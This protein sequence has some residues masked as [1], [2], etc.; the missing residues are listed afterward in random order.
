MLF[1]MDEQLSKNK[2]EGAYTNMMY[3]TYPGDYNAVQDNYGID[4]NQIKACENQGNIAHMY[5]D[6]AVRGLVDIN[7]YGV[8]PMGGMV[9]ARPEGALKVSPISANEVPKLGYAL[10]DGIYYPI[11]QPE[12]TSVNIHKSLFGVYT[13]SCVDLDYQ[14]YLVKKN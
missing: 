7:K 4:G 13:P 6:M 12:N 2:A 1:K 9:E 14:N 8:Y 10:K 5:R 11:N 3:Y